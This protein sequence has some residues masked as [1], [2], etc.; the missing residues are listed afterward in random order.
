MS[1][2]SRKGTAIK[3]YFEPNASCTCSGPESFRGRNV[4]ERRR[5]SSFAEL[6]RR[7]WPA[8]CR[9]EVVDFNETDASAIVQSREQRGVKARRQ[10]RSYG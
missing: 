8:A 4:F 7:D 3:S 6:R 1:Q 2:S 10:R 9:V 5:S